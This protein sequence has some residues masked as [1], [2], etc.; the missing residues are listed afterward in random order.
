LNRSRTNKA[1]KYT[2]LLDV[3]QES[4]YYSKTS[5]PFHYFNGRY[6]ELYAKNFYEF[7]DKERSASPVRECFKSAAEYG[8]LNKMLYVDT[9]TWLPDDL[10]V[11]ADKMTMANSVELRVPFLDHKVLEFAAGLP[12]NFK[13]RAF[14]TKYLAKRALSAR[15][16][17]EI[18]DR[19]KAGFPVPYESWLRD[20]LKGWLRDVLLD[21]KTLNRGY[22]EKKAIQDLLET[23][24]RSGG[25][26][27]E[28]FSL[29]VLELW[30]RAFLQNNNISA[31]S[32]A[33]SGELAGTTAATH[34]GVL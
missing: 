28:L 18:L 33:V 31:G 2:R 23:D 19:R 21:R 1:A 3:P 5:S 8:D 11:K 10:L 24:Q 13:M 27:K 29:A 26:S 16:P 9:K 6:Q 17:Q 7:V 4:Y 12:A 15:V 22:F 14:T 25:Y 32:S 34:A 30:H 20:D